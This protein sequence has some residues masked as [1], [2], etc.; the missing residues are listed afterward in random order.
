MKVSVAFITYN[1][2]PFVAQALESALMQEGVEFEI[3]V[4]EDRS[5]DRTREIVA[6]YAERNSERIR[7]LP[8]E[9][10]LGMHRNTER[11]LQ[12]CTGEFVALLEG[13]DY[14]TAPDKL[15]KQVE[16]L[17]RC[18]GYALCFHNVIVVYEDS[19]PSHPFRGDDSKTVF[20]AEE[21]AAE[22]FIS[23]CSAMLRNRPRIPYPGWLLRMP[24]L[25]WPLF[26]LCAERGAIAYLTDRM[27]AYRVHAGGIWASL[28]R[29][30]V[31]EKSLLA[32]RMIR[33]NMG[34]RYGKAMDRS[35]SRWHYEIARIL[36]DGKSPARAV[37][38]A[39]KSFAAC[40]F[41]PD[42]PK[43]ALREILR[44]ALF[45]GSRGAG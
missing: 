32:S 28:D 1:H 37:R 25:D 45:P 9:K 24:M 31:L 8:A 33:E 10:N 22:N 12:A 27:G 23:T 4:G 2:E 38:H 41:H 29:V 39:V 6:G 20:T 11:T 18:P 19:R 16:L 34:G 26:L 5:T 3:V 44:K 17:D 30:D 21:L 13:D 35:V 43:G 14:W 40:P 42:L 36:S 15:R 7:L